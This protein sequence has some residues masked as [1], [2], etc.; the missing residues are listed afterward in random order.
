[1]LKNIQN[2]LFLKDNK[3]TCPK[4]YNIIYIGGNKMEEK[5]DLMD[6]IAEMESAEMVVSD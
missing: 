5:I 2:N 6:E 3:V 1:M 4:K